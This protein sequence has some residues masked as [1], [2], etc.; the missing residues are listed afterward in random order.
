MSGV[1][2]RTKFYDYR[3]KSPTFS[4]VTDTAK[5]QTTRHA[6]SAVAIA[7]RH[8]PTHVK[9]IRELGGKEKEV[10]VPEQKPDLQTARWWLNNEKTSKKRFNRVIEEGETPGDTP[11][12]GVPENEEQ[13]ELMAMI[14]NKHYDYKKENRRA[15]RAAQQT[16]DTED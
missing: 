2:E 1:I 11:T 9:K 15:K 8:I 7:V 5:E 3:R 14:L 16:E 6:L 4:H 12:L 10:L 13:A